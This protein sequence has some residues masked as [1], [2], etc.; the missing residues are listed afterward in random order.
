MIFFNFSG[1]SFELGSFSTIDEVI[2]ID[3]G[4][5]FVR[6]NLNYVEGINLLELFGFSEGSTSHTGELVIET[7]E[8]LEGNCGERGRFLANLDTLFSL[9]GLMKTFV[10][11]TTVHETASVF[12]DN[13]N[14]TRVGYDIVFV[15]FEESLSAESLLHM[16]D[17]A[18]ISGRV[19]RLDTKDFLNFVDTFIGQSDSATLFVDYIV[20]IGKLSCNF[21]E[22]IITFWIVAGWSGNNEW[23]TGFINQDG[24][25]L[26]DD[27]EV[28]LA[29]TQI[30][31]VFDHVV[32]KV[33]ETELVVGHITKISL[34]AS[35]RFQ[36]FETRIIMIFVFIFGIIDKASFIN[37]DANGEAEEVIKFTHPTRITLSEI[38]VYSHNMNT[39]TCQGIE[40]DWEG[41]N[42]SFTFASFHLGDVALV[43]GDTA[44]KLNVKR[45][46]LKDALTGF[47]NERESV[48]QNLVKRLI[49]IGDINLLWIDFF[50]SLIG[51]FAGFD[52]GGRN[53]G[54]ILLLELTKTLFENFGLFL[55]F[56]F[57]H[58]GV[59]VGKLINLGN[60]TTQ[61]A[62]I[63]L[64]SVTK[65][66]LQEF[67]CCGFIGKFVGRLLFFW[68]FYRLFGFLC[69]HLFLMLR[70][71]FFHCN[72]IP[73][74]IS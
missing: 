11:T 73:R 41:C 54:L 32:A 10:V 20:I 66:M 40:V 15:A 4:N 62:K 14:F 27:C 74:L 49:S 7:E 72:S 56:F 71:L 58:A 48:W 64:L 18:S 69:F 50:G 3:T 34:F 70:P 16:I 5:L 55:K 13:Y 2:F 38:I 9:D 31:W 42:E 35:S 23:R 21:G 46:H 12:V 44:D 65:N 57:A 8:V 47:T 30:L 45:T 28:E 19:K 17:K 67:G 61:T 51:F 33:V 36:M 22:L 68:R 60:T 52:F 25:D 59:F 26:I 53:L 6:R 63:A 29:L 1:N 39:A 24:V 37:D 43:K